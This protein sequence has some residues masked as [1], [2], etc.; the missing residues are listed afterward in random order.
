MHMQSRTSLSDQEFGHTFFPPD[1]VEIAARLRHILSR[2]ISVDL[3]RLHP[4]DKLVEDIRMDALDSLSTVEFIMDVEK[5][6][7]ITVPNSVAKEMRT[8]RDVID[9]VCGHL[10][11]PIV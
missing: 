6:F 8:M 5:E 2:H 7:D 3:S 4:D 10:P 1:R 11:Q 9:Y